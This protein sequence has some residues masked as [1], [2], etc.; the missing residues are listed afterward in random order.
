MKYLDGRLLYLYS[1]RSKVRVKNI[2]RNFLN[3]IFA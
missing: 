1:K 2:I 3:V